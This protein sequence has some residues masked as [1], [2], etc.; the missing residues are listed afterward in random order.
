VRKTYIKRIEMKKTLTQLHYTV[1]VDLRKVM[2]IDS[3]LE[4]DNRWDDILNA[5]LDRIEGLCDTDYNGHFGNFIFITIDAEYDHLHK[6]EEIETTIK[7]F[8][9]G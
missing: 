4:N 9:K 7:N 8:L 6:W 1:E 5:K 2:D 3:E